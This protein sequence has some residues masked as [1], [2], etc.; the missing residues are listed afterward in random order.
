MGGG[1]LNVE[2]PCQ[3]AETFAIRVLAIGIRRIPLVGG[4]CSAYELLLPFCFGPLVHHAFTMR[5]NA[6]NLV[7]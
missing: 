5:S 3:S 6:R 2:S 7:S 1:L 4:S